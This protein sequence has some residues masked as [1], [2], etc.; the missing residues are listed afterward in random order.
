MKLKFFLSIFLSLILIFTFA[1]S[2]FAF[3]PYASLSPSS[4]YVSILYGYYSNLDDFSPFDYFVIFQ[5]SQYSYILYYNL[6]N[7]ISSYIRYSRSGS[8][9]SQWSISEGTAGFNII[10]SSDYTYIS[11]FNGGLLPEVYYFSCILYLL[12]YV[13]PALAILFI[14]YIFRTKKKVLNL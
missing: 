4:S 12:K 2:S 5:E 3:S 14:F 10:N 13:L 9:N 6:D 1:F 8:V 7:Q 11:N